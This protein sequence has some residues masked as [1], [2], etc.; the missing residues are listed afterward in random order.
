[1]NLG[2]KVRF[3]GDD[4]IIPKGSIGVLINIDWLNDTIT[5]KFENF[6][7]HFT[8]TEFKELIDLIVEV[9][10][11]VPETLKK[12]YYMTQKYIGVKND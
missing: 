3:K 5:V 8:P 1:M 4:P 7:A 10:I 6:V 12:W 9:K 2:D 11:P